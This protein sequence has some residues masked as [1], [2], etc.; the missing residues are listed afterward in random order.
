M[1]AAIPI[2]VLAILAALA[3]VVATIMIMA[4]LNRRGV[5]TS[6]LWARLYMIKYVHQY[7]QLTESETGVDAMDLRVAL[8]SLEPD[9][10][11]LLAMRYV[12][13]FTSNELAGALGITPSGV[14]GRLE[15]LTTRLRRE[16]SHA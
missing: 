1:A 8:A 11:A 12:A 9:D 13:G 16:L 7:R 14:R 15:R 4:E 10:R 2:L 6:I 3:N 5:Q